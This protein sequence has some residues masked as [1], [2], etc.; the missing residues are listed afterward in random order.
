[1]RMRMRMKLRM[2]RNHPVYFCNGSIDSSVE[3]LNIDMIE[4]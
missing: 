4:P 1:M 2:R 3:N